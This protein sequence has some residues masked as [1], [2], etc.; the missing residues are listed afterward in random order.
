M[1][2]VY[3]GS[4]GPFNDEHILARALAGSGENWMLKELVCVKCNKLFSTYERKWTSEP[5]VAMARIYWGPAGRVRKGQAYQVHPSE[6]IFLSAKDDAVAY[7][8]DILRGIEPRLRAQV[9]STQSAL[10][11][12]ASDSDGAQRLTDATNAFLKDR[13]ITIQKRRSNQ[14]RVAI[15]A[16]EGTP[17]FERL[18]WR[19]TPPNAWVD[20]FPEGHDLA[21][22]PRMSVDAFGR[23]RFRVRKLRDV[24]T[25]LDR[26][27]KGPIT[28]PPARVIEAGKYELI[29]LSK[30]RRRIN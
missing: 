29:V 28:S 23:L 15:L 4:A 10:F 17:R 6:N 20:W 2:C 14:F 21:P 19:D 22:N 16:L 30:A 24:T 7:E 12:T 1:T 8:V 3:C 26:M 5:G 27:F 25:L 13:A 18:E 9:I 11:V